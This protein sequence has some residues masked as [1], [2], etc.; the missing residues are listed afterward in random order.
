M[1]HILQN[2]RRTL[3]SL[4][5]SEDM[6]VII[7][8][9]QVYRYEGHQLF[10]SG[11]SKGMGTCSDLHNIDIA[12]FEYGL[13]E[14]QRFIPKSEINCAWTAVLRDPYFYE[15]ARDDPRAWLVLEGLKPTLAEEMFINFEYSG[16][17]QLYVATIS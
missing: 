8:P 9:R 16:K 17:L 12:V 6:E 1:A 13:K 11:I 7:R 5:P 14:K 2:Q 4:R 15:V 10:L 3:E